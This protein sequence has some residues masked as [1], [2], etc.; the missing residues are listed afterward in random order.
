MKFRLALFAPAVLALAAP[1]AAQPAPAPAEP[2]PATPS[3]EPTVPPV[4][5][6]PPG[7]G[8]PA[9]PPAPAESS[10]PGAAPGPGEVTSKWSATIY[11][12][13]EVDLMHDTTQS[14]TESPGNGLIVRPTGLTYNN[15]RTQTTARNS[16]LGVRLN[17]PAFEGMKAS[18]NVE[19][20]FMGYQPGIAPANPSV[21]EASFFNNGTFR[22]RAAYAKVESEYVDLLAGQYYFLF[23]EQPFFQP[24]SIWFFGL[25]NMAFGRT[26]QF[27]LSHTFKSEAANVDLA[28]SA[29]RPPQRDS[30]I[31]DFQG[32]LK[33][34]INSWKGVHAGGSGYAAF[35][36]L[37]VAVSGSVRHFRVNDF[38][39]APTSLRTINGWG[40]SLDGMIPIIPA[41]SA[42]AKGNA[43]TLTGSFV[44]GSGIGDLIG[45][46]TG[47]A[48]FPAVPA[49]MPGGASTPYPANVDPGIIQYDTM[50]NLRAINWQT[51][52]V[53][54]QY[55]VPPSGRIS[56][57]ANYTLGKSD[58]IT[59]G[60]TG[61]ALAGVFKESQYFEAVVIGDLTP[62]VRIGAA[63]QRTQQT[64]GDEAVSKNNRLEL[65]VY[66][67]F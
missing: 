30:E 14:F 35:D 64:R 54:A 22:M 61:N 4:P 49:A 13:A 66:F 43:L 57:G 55:F 24:M 16:R 11:G 26:Q 28:V 63:W 7:T 42:K 59:D 48:A 46:L 32:G 45:G 41:A 33:V 50:G 18:G 10:K 37:T 8:Q 2:A 65:S 51:L 9:P 6:A 20:D 3:T 56:I 47:G 27:R 67:F 58:N 36:P 53:G 5:T 34:G 40:I 15:G 62:A 44:M 17:A 39:A 25:P 12:F 60:L 1:A 23:G 21:S 31:P 52:V 29:Q 38:A 19:M